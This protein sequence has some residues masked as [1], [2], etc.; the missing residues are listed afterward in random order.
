MLLIV[1]TFILG[2]NLAVLVVEDIKADSSYLAVLSRFIRLLLC[3][4]ESRELQRTVA[5]FLFMQKP[6]VFVLLSVASCFYL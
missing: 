1:S 2:G 3:R 5:V 4:S 6:P